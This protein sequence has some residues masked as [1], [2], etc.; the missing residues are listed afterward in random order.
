MLSPRVRA[1]S[2]PHVRCPYLCMHGGCITPPSSFS[3]APSLC[4]TLGAP[5]RQCG[6]EACARQG[7]CV[8]PAERC[9][10]TLVHK[11]RQRRGER[12]SHHQYLQCHCCG[13]SSPASQTNVTD[14][15]VHPRAHTCIVRHRHGVLAAPEEEKKNWHLAHALAI[16]CTRVYVCMY[17]YVGR[18]TRECVYRPRKERRK[19]GREAGAPCLHQHSIGT[20][21]VFLSPQRA[22]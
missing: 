11:H 20:V 9:A 15:C 12:H 22:P 13:F 10:W 16:L 3:L 6:G 2:A 17:V 8:Y 21:A 19:K 7:R 14:A 18:R 4:P 1:K 5:Y